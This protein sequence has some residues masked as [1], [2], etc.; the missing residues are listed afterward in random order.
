M[1]PDDQ[2]KAVFADTVRRAGTLF[3]ALDT[4]GDGVLSAAEIAAAPDVLRALAADGDGY[5]R[6]ADFGG[7]TE[8]YGAIRRSSIL[9]MLD[10]DGDLVVT[11][12]DI[13]AASERI[14]MLDSDGDG[15]VT[16]ADDI[17][18][19]S[20][21]M[22]NTMPMGTPAQMLAFQKRMFG[23]TAALAGPLPPTGQPEVQ[24]GYILVQ[25][26]NDRSDVQMSKRMFLMD[27]HGKIVQ[28][29]DTPYHTPEATSAYLLESGHLLR[30]TS[31]AH[32]LEMEHEFPVG[33]HGTITIE[34]KASNIIWEWNHYTPKGECAH[35]DVE[36]MPNGNLLSIAW[37][38]VPSEQANAQGWVQQGDRERIILDKIIEVKPDYETGG[39]EIIWEWSVLDH[40]IQN[41]DPSLPNYGEP[42]DHPEKID[43]NWPQLDEIQFNYGQLIHMNSVSY[44]AEKDLLMLS[45]A[46]FGE[47]WVIDH[48]TTWEE[49]KGSTG[50]RYGRGGDL[51]WRWG[52]PQTYGTGDHTDQVLYWQHDT[53]WLTDSVPHTGD[54]MVFNNGMRRDASGNAEYDQICM[55]MI[56]G[57][58]ADVLELKLPWD[59]D[60]KLA[61]GNQAE[62]TWSYNSDGKDDV[63]SP[64]MSGAQ[65]MPNGNT[66]MVQAFDKR[67]VEVNPDGEMVLDFHVGGPGRMF[68]VYKYAPDFPGIVALGLGAAD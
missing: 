30:A 54:M 10:L 44:N 28:E 55:G 27:D 67:I 22:E 26:M 43:I 64:F 57:A 1:S 4:D 9:R 12:E 15:Q 32:Y 11:P 34:D 23:R 25:E 50:G 8:I 65:R 14:L 36:M 20:A 13:D 63:Y 19:P 18:P 51:L 24:P 41:V 49:S 2:A 40:V 66:I 35:H 6:E 45:S 48:S 31:K 21:N 29:W 3:R 46:I 53:Y 52:N 42:A 38:Y 47:A 33:G 60:G 17:P 16:A 39:S 37:V 61:A 58:F 5:L 62:I 59:G 7:P 68:R 56:D